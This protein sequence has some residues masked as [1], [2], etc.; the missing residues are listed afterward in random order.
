MLSE[1]SSFVNRLPIWLLAHLALPNSLQG[2]EVA[3]RGRIYRGVC[4]SKFQK[5]GNRMGCFS[6][7]LDKMKR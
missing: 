6:D 1:S 2:K 5:N 4:E 7:L 3:L